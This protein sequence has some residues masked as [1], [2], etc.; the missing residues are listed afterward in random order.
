MDPDDLLNQ[1]YA[2][3][4]LNPNDTPRATRSL[5]SEPLSNASGLLQGFNNDNQQLQFLNAQL[6]EQEKLQ[7]QALVAQQKQLREEQARQEA[8]EQ[9]VAQMQQLI[10]QR[11]EKQVFESSGVNEE[12]RLAY[13]TEGTPEFGV[14]QSMLLAAAQE[15]KGRITERNS[16]IDLTNEDQRTNALNSTAA[17][18]GLVALQREI[19]AQIPG[20][21]TQDQAREFLNADD[22]VLAAGGRLVRNTLGSAVG[23]LGDVT[24]LAGALGAGI[25]GIG[26]GIDAAGQFL[27][28]QLFERGEQA[29]RSDT[30][31]GFLGN[32]ALSDAVGNFG[33]RGVSGTAAD[34]AS[35]IADNPAILGSVTAE[36]LGALLGGG[37][38]GAGARVAAGGTRAGQA[39]S[40]AL[41]STLGA[42]GRQVLPAVTVS[43]ASDLAGRQDA[44]P[45]TGGARA[46]DALGALGSAG[47]TGLATRGLDRLGLGTAESAV[48]NARRANA[49]GGTG[50]APASTPTNAVFAGAGN[51]VSGGVRNALGEAGQEITQQLS[52]DALIDQQLS[53]GGDL[54][55]AGVLG[56]ALGGVTGAPSGVIQ[57]QRARADE[58]AARAENAAR[59]QEQTQLLESNPS[60][61]LINPGST[62]NPQD[63][64]FV[65]P[66][67]NPV[68]RQQQAQQQA[69]AQQEFL[70][71][72]P[73][74]SLVNPQGT[75]NQQD[76]GFVGPRVT[77]TQLRNN[78]PFSSPDIQEVAG[79][80]SEQSQEAF[81]NAAGRATDRQR[82]FFS[83]AVNE[84]VGAQSRAESD[85]QVST[86]SITQAL[87]S[88]G[89]N[90]TGDIN[91]DVQSVADIAR[92]WAPEELPDGA[93][94]LSNPFGRI[95]V[96]TDGSASYQPITGGEP[97][98]FDSLVDARDANLNTA[99]EWVSQ[100]TANGGTIQQAVEQARDQSE[101]P[102]TD[103]RT[104]RAITPAQQV[105]RQRN[106]DNTQRRSRAQFTEAERAA[107]QTSVIRDLNQPRPEPAPEP[108][109]TPE[110]AP[111]P[112][113]TPTREPQTTA[114]AAQQA[115][116][117]RPEPTT[118]E[119][120]QQNVTVDSI[121]QNGQDA[122]AQ[123]Q[124]RDQ[125]N[126]ARAAN[127]RTAIQRGSIPAEVRGETTVDPTSGSEVTTAPTPNNITPDSITDS[128]TDSAND[129]NADFNNAIVSARGV[130]ADPA[131]SP[132][133]R[134]A[135]LGLL[136][137][138]AAR[139]NTLPADLQAQVNDSQ[140]SS[141]ETGA[142]SAPVEQAPEITV[143]NALNN[144]FGAPTNAQD[145]A[146][147][148]RIQI[149]DDG[150]QV[151][152]SADPE[153]TS[154]RPAEATVTPPADASTEVVQPSGDAEPTDL[155]FE[156][157]SRADFTDIDTSP[158][159]GALDRQVFSAIEDAGVDSERANPSAANL[160]D[161]PQEVDYNKVVKPTSRGGRTSELG[162]AQERAIQSGFA[163]LYQVTE[164]SG[165]GRPS[166]VF[167]AAMSLGTVLERLRDRNF[168]EISKL[169]SRTGE[170]DL[171][172]VPD[173]D[174]TSATQVRQSTEASGENSPGEFEPAQGGQTA[175]TAA[176]AAESDAGLLGD[177]ETP[178]PKVRLKSRNFVT[179]SVRNNVVPDPRDYRYF[180]TLSDD[181]N[182]EYVIQSLSGAPDLGFTLF[183][184]DPAI[185]N[186]G[187]SFERLRDVRDFINTEILTDGVE[188]IR[189]SSDGF[190][191]EHIDKF[192]RFK[193]ELRT[194]RDIAAAANPRGDDIVRSPQETDRRRKFVDGHVN[195]LR[196]K[197]RGTKVF[198]FEGRDGLDGPL[199]RK[200]Q[201][202][203]GAPLDNSVRGFYYN[204]SVYLN[205][206]ALG[207]REH[208]EE[209]LAH[210]I[211]GHRGLRNK[212]GAN[213]NRELDQM[214]LAMGGING[215]VNYAR[216]SGIAIGPYQ[217]LIDQ[218]ND[219]SDPNRIAARRQLAEE[220]IAL[221][222][223]N[224]LESALMGN[225][226]N[227]AAKIRQLVS[228]MFP[229]IA[230]FF[231]VSMSPVD[232]LAYAAR[233]LQCVATC[234][235][236]LRYKITLILSLS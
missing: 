177:V 214:T 79:A 95:T 56:G 153:P 78:Q 179:G 99:R 1:V 5:T 58:G 75:G 184:N 176:P 126:L 183:S 193:K 152:I 155:D 74:S 4:G 2:Q 107:G 65:G 149:G 35:A 172:D 24:E 85:A 61:S 33:E 66:Q 168:S 86:D 34:I 222:M 128:D 62:G 218:A 63:F 158:T 125:E 129:S 84:T 190:I 6:R 194:H 15:E 53:D 231:N 174:L 89:I 142:A 92:S 88:E 232:V 112:A 199:Q 146:P 108:A 145:I 167:P 135:V 26:G 117:N 69:Q 202:D 57:G 32:Q 211:L 14:F 228:R 203:H 13:Y 209:T 30:A 11:V 122:I 49:R 186:D 201:A 150:A 144:A 169:R 111:E 76:F 139:G 119:E 123:Q 188:Q 148:S 7:R 8:Q 77:D 166:F 41:D 133:N 17:A 38:L 118:P 9:E 137:D 197:L 18:D 156:R 37:A 224:Y 10:R 93:T 163:T 72:N 46:L 220:V 217:S 141:G 164:H 80:P 116:A 87:Q 21:P 120:A 106:R 104:G 223:P 205:S 161:N 22:G 136:G 181:A 138:M 40:R 91:Q 48:L 102:V 16:R 171:A 225:V 27:N 236:T 178:R 151:P 216:D 162:Q 210:E 59:A 94:L 206:E 39:A 147:P 159:G 105:Q 51:A 185:P 45:E 71:T 157:L 229:N 124:A 221:S 100:V 219:T 140:A 90:T 134:S 192:A 68:A 233:V 23:G 97:V 165:R 52:A 187:R 55:L 132:A 121:I 83:R 180:A 230:D 109:P 170:A 227:A 101:S 81:T 42:A 3:L 44:N 103:T 47:V 226:R 215:L 212:F 127:V 182:Y 19:V 196:R 70:E 208:I 110:P 195:T 29:L 235:R 198:V 20:A 131:T 113:P 96:E 98:Q 31:G 60:S 12:D 25:P 175:E 67:D 73:S 50:V 189:A 130:L 64:G 115:L 173:A 54:T 207:T 204:G 143:E 36:T 82:D 213:L 191:N 160:R 43:A 114:N 234:R 28:D 200:F 154:A